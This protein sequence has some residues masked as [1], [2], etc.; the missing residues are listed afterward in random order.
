MLVQ[1]YFMHKNNTMLF[2]FSIKVF[3]SADQISHIRYI[4]TFLNLQ[5][6]DLNI[7][8]LPYIGCASVE[9]SGKTVDAP[10]CQNHHCFRPLVKSAYPKIFFLFLIQNICCGYSKEPSQ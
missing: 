10:A 3:G 5:V 4:E 2:L 7:Q 6:T 9:C 1:N 8:L